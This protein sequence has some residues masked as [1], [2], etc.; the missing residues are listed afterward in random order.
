MWL[1][2]H[3]CAVVTALVP[4]GRAAAWCRTFSPDSAEAE[5]VMWPLLNYS[6]CPTAIFP[7]LWI[8]RF[9]H[10]DSVPP[11]S[12]SR[13]GP[14]RPQ[15]H[16]HSRCSQPRVEQGRVVIAR[17]MGFLLVAL[18]LWESLKGGHHL[19]NGPVSPGQ[20]SVPFPRGSLD[21]SWSLFR[22]LA[23]SR[24]PEA[25]TCAPQDPPTESEPSLQG[26]QV[27]G[28]GRVL[29]AATGWKQSTSNSRETGA[30]EVAGWR[31]GGENFP[32]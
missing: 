23:G 3:L 17:R 30:E 1:T 14:C 32:D 8:L 15:R 16:P 31:E 12:P 11:A 25:V 18:G 27:S 19:S 29:C 4:P 21:C 22:Q 7:F 24:S 9:P 20:A 10:Q 5:V 28:E 13:P 2:A 6:T 26:P